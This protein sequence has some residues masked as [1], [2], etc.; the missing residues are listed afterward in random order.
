MERASSTM[1]PQ[2]LRLILY[3]LSSCSDMTGQPCFAA[4]LSSSFTSEKFHDNDRTDA[5]EH[6]VVTDTAKPR[7]RGSLRINE[8]AHR[9]TT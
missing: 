5:V 7:F 1:G 6:T 8:F 3:S 9:V 4:S 2:S